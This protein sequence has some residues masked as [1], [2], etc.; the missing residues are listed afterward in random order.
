MLVVVS[1]AIAFL[2]GWV[3]ASPAS[4]LDGSSS[5]DSSPESELPAEGVT[6]LDEGSSSHPGPTESELP[7][8]GTRPL[9]PGGP[10]VHTDGPAAALPI[11]GAAPMPY[12]PPAAPA[13][14]DPKAT[15]MARLDVGLGPV[16]RIRP[17]DTMLT[18]G[19]AYG[20]MHGFSGTFHTTM[21]VVTDRRSVQAFDFPI[22]VGAVAR[23]R[24]RSRPMY[25]SVGLTAGILVHR[26]RTEQGIVRR[27]DPDLRVPLRFDWTV[28]RAMGLSLALVPGYSVRE[29]SYERRGAVVWNRHS[30]RLGLVIGLHWDIVEGR[31]KAR[32]SGDHRR[33]G[34]R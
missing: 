2:L 30:V 6:P 9:S 16:W 27:V 10:V 25:G 20:R 18:I 23:G 28:T 11:T 34:E 26:A 33:M 14:I 24:L 22:G 17:V 4:P 5:S 13:A 15:R 7:V 12:R 1:P 21:I 31:A 29:R 3:V 32:R 8:D 19:M